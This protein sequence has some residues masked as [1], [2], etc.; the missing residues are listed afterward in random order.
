[1]NLDKSFLMWALSYA[2]AGLALGIYMAATHN[3]GELVT[4]AHILLIGFVLSLVYGIIHKL[5]LEKPNRTVAKAQFVVHQAA[6]V[7]VSVGLFLV[8]GNMVPE[9]TLGPVLG[10]ASAGVLVGMLLMLYMVVRF[11]GNKAA[12]G[13]S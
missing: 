7:T 5:W 1:M 13:G 3:H 11:E 8:Y 10:I 9:S 6:A 12:V 2:A 4:H